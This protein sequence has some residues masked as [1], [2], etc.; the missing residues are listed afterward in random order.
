MHQNLVMRDVE[1]ARNIVRGDLDLVVCAV[2]GFVSN[3]AFD[4]GKLSYGEAYDN[5]QDHSPAFGEHVEALLHR[6]LHEKG[7]QQ[8]RI[9]EVGCGKGLFLRR[10]VKEGEGNRGYGFDPSYLG[11]LR[12][13]DGR[14]T[15]EKRYYGEEGTEVPADVVVCRHVIEHV[16]EP[17]VL[18][19]SIRRAL[20]SSPHARVFFETPCLEWILRNQVIWD[21]F[22]EH[23]S[24]FTANSLRTAF[25]RSGFRVEE[26]RHVFGGQ[27]LWLEAAVAD[28]PSEGTRQAGQVLQLAREFARREEELIASWHERINRAAERGNVALWGAGAKGVT[29]ANLIDPDRQRVVC[30]VDLNPVKQGR[31]LPGTGHPIVGYHQLPHYGVDVAVQMNPNYRDENLAL[32]QEA[33]LNISLI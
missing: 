6:L 12:D 4:L 8:C 27:Y 7:V 9:V 28:E 17:L 32:L 11:P 24:Y 19:R 26:V 14:L 33:G 21:F 20:D 13:L 22:Y 18:L 15:F 1:A 31:F 29:F 10:L 23:C 30:V 5:T 25:E 16:P 2:C 3:R